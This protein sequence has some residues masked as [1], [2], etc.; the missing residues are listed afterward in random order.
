MDKHEMIEALRKSINNAGVAIMNDKV[1][2]KAFLSDF[3]PGYTYKSE[4]MA[5]IHALEIDEWKI[6]LDVHGKGQEEHKRAKKV[7]LTQLQDILGWTNERSSLILECYT[8]AMGWKDADDLQTQPDDQLNSQLYLQPKTQPQ[9]STTTFFIDDEL[10]EIFQPETQPQTGTTTFSID[11]ELDKI[12]GNGKYKNNSGGQSLHP[13][14]FVSSLPPVV[15]P[16]MKSIT[17]TPA[18][19]GNYKFGAYDWRV[20]D[21]QGDRALLVS[22][23]IIAKKEYNETYT[24]VTWE[25]CTLRK[26]LNKDFLHTFNKKD[27]SRIVITKNPNEDNQWYGTNGGGRTKNRI[28]L[29]SISEVVKYLGDS[30]QLK[31]KNL[32]LKSWIQDQ[33]NSE[34]ISKFNNS[35]SWWWLRSPGDGSGNAAVVY[36]DGHL[37][38]NGG[39]V[40]FESG[41]V[42]PA[43]W[44]KL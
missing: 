13:R 31:N 11:D 16:S 5:L 41:G 8:T 23:D 9:T 15:V 30:G 37:I 22:K 35:R 20:L 10:D 39:N 38:M 12:F 24:A 7:L 19:G 2:L 25:T 33:F 27:Q 17:V 36:D 44:L 29:L 18:I 14:N 32:K 6:L 42:R 40:S 3:L 28:F 34:R 4:R 1:K 26:W 43:L 21:V